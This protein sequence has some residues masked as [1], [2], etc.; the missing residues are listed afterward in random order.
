MDTT[1]APDNH[2]TV[3]SPAAPLFG[4]QPVAG[5]YADPHDAS[6][7]RWW[8][9]AVW[10]EH[11][12]PTNGAGASVD[13]RT[14]ASFWVRAGAFVIDTILLSTVTQV[15]MFITVAIAA[16]AGAAAGSDEFSESAW[17]GILVGVVWA[18]SAV[19]WV[20]YFAV[21]EARWGQTVGKRAVGIE[22]VSTAGG[23]VSTGR[24]VARH[25]ARLLSALPLYLGYFAML[26]SPKRQTWH[27]RLTGSVVVRSGR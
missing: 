1:P 27:D 13:G 12:H 23:R 26:W 15:V 16:V 21:S 4:Q 8:D 5:W 14:Y 17:V 20:A 7:L 19:A 24:A 2:P 9:G 25:F 10:T 22:V 11:R 18:G 3:G 6:Q